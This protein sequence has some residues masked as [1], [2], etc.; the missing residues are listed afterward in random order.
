MIAGLNRELLESMMDHLPHGVSVVNSGMRLVAWNQRYVEL[1]DY[2][3]G[4]VY[5]GQPIGESILLNAQRGLYGPGD[6]QFHVEKQ[7][8][9]LRRGA[10]HSF[11]QMLPDGKVIEVCGQRLPDGGFV[12]TFSDITRFKRVE[13]DLRDVDSRLTPQQF[14]VLGMLCSGLP[15]KQIGAQLNVTEATVK[16][17]M[18]AIM[19]K[20][21]ASNRTQVVLIA[22][23]LSLDQAGVAAGAH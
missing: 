21:G 3:V 15:N 1:F 4:F 20:F 17:H 12:T 13:P 16:A 14:R 10:S 9:S 6:P 11:E 8:A 2:P 22:Q 19:E 5:A 23:R 18:R 7:L